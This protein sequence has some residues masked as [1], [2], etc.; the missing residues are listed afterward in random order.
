[1]KIYPYKRLSRP[2][3]L[4]VTSVSLTLPDRT[5]DPLDTSAHSTQEQAVALGVAGHADWVSA[6]AARRRRPGRGL[7]GSAR[8]RRTDRRGDQRPY[9]D[10]P[11]TG[12]GEQP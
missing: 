7:V 10:G 8:P 2:I 1:V 4:R 5:R 12:H 9:L 3:T 6:A 11:H